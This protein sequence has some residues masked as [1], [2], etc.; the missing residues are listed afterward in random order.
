M[1]VDEFVRLCAVMDVSLAHFFCADPD[2]VTVPEL[3]WRWHEQR[4]LL[5]N[6]SPLTHKTDGRELKKVGRW[7]TGVLVRDGRAT[8]VEEWRI[9][10][11][12]V[13][14]LLEIQRESGSPRHRRGQAHRL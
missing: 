9:T 8:W 1:H 11:S 5:K 2:K 12:S 4:K 7:F 13:A 6:L 14:E 10:V 3:G